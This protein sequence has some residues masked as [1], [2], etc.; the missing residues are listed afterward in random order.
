MGETTAKT[1]NEMS[2]AERDAFNTRLGLMSEKQSVD[3]VNRQLEIDFNAVLKPL[4]TPKSETE[5]EVWWPT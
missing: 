5:G 2:Q 4:L 3:A 1:W